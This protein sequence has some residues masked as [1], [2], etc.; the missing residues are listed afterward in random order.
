[1]SKSTR[2][3]VF[4]AVLAAGASSRFG[5][6]KQLAEI[7]G[8]SLVRQALDSAVAACGANTVLVVGHDWKAV[9]AM[10][11]ASPGFL[12]VN[13]N[14]SDGLGTSVAQAVRS[15]QHAAD[16]IIVMLA[17]QALVTA[18]HVQAITAAW[19]GADNEIVATAFEETIGPPVLFPRACFDE[20]A[21][22]Q[23]DAGGRHLLSDDRFTVK[24]IVFEPAAVD[25]DTPDD[26]KKF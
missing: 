4:A 18:E 21:A 11:T 20:L 25:I 22:L 2:K 6:S 1:V 10:C 12:I 24:T 9:S 13:N 23:G 7:N 17:D 15:I 26:L 14:Y 3:S 5:S 19:C 16:A 8:V